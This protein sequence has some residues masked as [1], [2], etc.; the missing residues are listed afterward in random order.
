VTGV[1]IRRQRTRTCSSGSLPPLQLV[2][3]VSRKAILHKSRMNGSLARDADDEAILKCYTEET[4]QQFAGVIKSII[5]STLTRALTLSQERMDGWVRE[6]LEQSIRD[7]QNALASAT[8]GFRAKLGGAWGRL[9]WACFAGG[10]IAAVLLL[11]GGFSLGR[12]Y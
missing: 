3:A 12:N 11:A 9:L 4:R 5:E 6:T 8:A 10:L 2:R 7:A 1:E